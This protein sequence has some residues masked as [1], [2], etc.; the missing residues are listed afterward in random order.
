MNAAAVMAV[1]F[2]VAGGC[3]PLKVAIN[4]KHLLTASSQSRISS[5]QVKRTAISALRCGKGDMRPNVV[6]L[7]T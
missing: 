1:A 5:Y 3:S 7:L 2:M 4:I 6:E